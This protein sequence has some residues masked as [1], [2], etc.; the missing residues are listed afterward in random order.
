MK[1]CAK[2]LFYSLAISAFMCCGGNA[3][4]K[5]SPTA[6]EVTVTTFEHHEIYKLDKNA[7]ESPTLEFDF[8]L[9]LI[10]TDDS[11]AT[12]NINRVIA[13]TLFESNKSS[14]EEACRDFMEHRKI[15]YKELLPIYN[16]SHEEGDETWFSS[17]YIGNSEVKEGYKGLLNYIT[18]WEAY[19]GGAHPIS[20]Y[21][22][23]NFNPETG[24]EIVLDEILKEGYEEALTNLLI[25]NLAKQL[26]V[27]GIEGIREKGYLYFD[28]EMFISNNFIL[29]KEKISFIYNVYE[30]APY[31]F[32]EI[33]IDITYEELK[34][35]LK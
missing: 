25:V 23:L 34:D 33:V 14:I 16:E 32:G 2:I 5:E 6:S 19:S 1:K 27:E 8:S 4:K 29:G 35:L 28:N 17:Y 20:Y 9:S 15:E 30:I 26:Q 3:G 18:M 12:A 24:E 31:A 22:V 13:Y 10:E 11:I 7:S 21:T